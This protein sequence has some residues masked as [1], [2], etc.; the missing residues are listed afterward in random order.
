M[1]GGAAVR[2]Y[3]CVHSVNSLFIQLDVARVLIR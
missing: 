2:V 1:S 3:L